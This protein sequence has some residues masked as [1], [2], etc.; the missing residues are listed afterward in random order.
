MQTIENEPH[1][2]SECAI[3]STSTIGSHTELTH[4]DNPKSAAAAEF[5]ELASEILMQMEMACQEE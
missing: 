5:I 1:I 2:S 4:N 3:K